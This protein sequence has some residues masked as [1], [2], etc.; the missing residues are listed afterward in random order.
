[1][2]LPRQRRRHPTAAL[3]GATGATGSPVAGTCVVEAEIELIEAR[4]TRDVVASSIEVSNGAEDGIVV[5]VGARDMSV[6]IPASLHDESRKAS[7][8][9]EFKELS[10]AASPR[11]ALG[12]G[13]VTA[14]E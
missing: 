9:T 10:A 8:E 7:E 6:A 13:I 3:E 12:R 5:V 1:M 2:S 11:R 14:L 4:A